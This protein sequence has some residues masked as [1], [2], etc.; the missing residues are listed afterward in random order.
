MTI[1][2][3]PD[4]TLPAERID[5]IDILR[6]LALLGVLLVNIDTA[7]RTT[8][9]EQFTEAPAKGAADRIAQLA[10]W[11]GFEFKAF[12]LF[13]L[14]F[15]A[16][17]AMQQERF[18]ARSGKAAWR[19]ARRQLVL[20]AFGLVHLVL[21]W[22]GDILTEY[23]AAGLIV[24]P[25]LFARTGVTASA[26]ALLLLF[27]LWQPWLIGDLGLPGP[28]DMI[29]HIADAR[30]VYG[31][32]GFVEV[33]RF[34]IGELPFI[35]PLHVYVLARTVGLMLLGA[36]AWKSGVIREW[37]RY[38]GLFRPL[39]AVCLTSGVVLTLIG[40]GDA[41]ADALAPI[42]LAVGYASL[43]LG[44]GEAARRL[45]RWVAPLGRMAFTNYIAQSVIL[46]LIF[47]G[48]G[49][50]LLGY[51]GAATGVAMGLALFLTQ[52]AFSVVWLQTHRFGP[53]E[54][55]WRSLTYGRPQ[56]WR[57]DAHSR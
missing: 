5:L 19:L 2:A 48:Y 51:V 10:L 25:L 57:A 14:L 37:R 40:R 44:F 9:F 45:F 18:A 8:L 38:A 39:A 7:F 41:L 6:G 55:L 20:L 29:Q 53:L 35:V 33:L 42:L 23:A 11:L 22:N 27:Y 46:G 30:R 49:F 4:P 24:L 1:D 47:F 31:T 13:S 26:A 12:A 50:G 21:I 52:A 15:G 34:S 16:G 43:L 54:W 36:V 17:M 3:S 28:A 56:V 32:G